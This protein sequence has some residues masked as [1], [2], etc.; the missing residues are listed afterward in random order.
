MQWIKLTSISIFLPSSNMNSFISQSF[1]HHS[2]SSPHPP[3]SIPYYSAWTYPIQDSSYKTSSC[4][5]SRTTTQTTQ[6]TLPKT[7]PTLIYDPAMFCR[8]PLRSGS[9]VRVGI[10]YPACP[11]VIT[12]IWWPLRRWRIVRCRIIFIAGFYFKCWS[13]RSSLV[14]R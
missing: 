14:R 11:K 3:H 13:G 2:L 12:P 1:N 5:T 9:E 4:Y 10:E 8:S 6:T 7:H